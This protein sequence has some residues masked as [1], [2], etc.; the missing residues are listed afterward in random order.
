MWAVLDFSQSKVVERELLLVKVSI[1]PQEHL[2]AVAATTDNRLDGQQ[3]QQDVVGS[4]GGA[5]HSVSTRYL[6]HPSPLLPISSSPSL[7]SQ[8]TLLLLALIRISLFFRGIIKLSFSTYGVRA[9]ATGNHGSS[10]NL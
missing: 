3:Q 10:Q 1:V 4:G 9:A 5:S 8:S 7:P 6:F 2:M